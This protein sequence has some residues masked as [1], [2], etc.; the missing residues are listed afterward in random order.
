MAKHSL[1]DTEELAA[2]YDRIARDYAKDHAG[3][4]WAY[5]MREGFLALLPRHARVLDVGCGP[6]F[7]ARHFAAVGHRV[8]GI[9]VAPR[10]LA[11]AKRNV[12]NGTFLRMDMRALSFEDAVFDGA[13]AKGSLLHLSRREALPVLRELHR[14]LRPHGVCFVSVKGGR[15]SAAVAESDYGYRYARPFTNFGRAEFRR[16]L[17]RAGFRVRE[18]VERVKHQ[19]GKHPW[20]QFLAEK[21]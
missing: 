15:G 4:T 9:D 18:E 10:F 7:D 19:P 1:F 3:D 16:L 20:L 21:Q 6:G 5:S 12:P 2:T 17:T 8:T 13:W 14:V 11:M